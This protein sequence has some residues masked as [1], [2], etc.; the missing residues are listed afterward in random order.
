L[1]FAIKKYHEMWGEQI[2]YTFWKRN[3]E[4]PYYFN[5]KDV[6]GIF[7]IIR[8]I[9]MKDLAAVEEAVGLDAK[10]SSRRKSPSEA[11]IASPRRQLQVILCSYRIF[12]WLI[13]IDLVYAYG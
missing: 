12:L 1:F 9:K 2:E 8:N 13:A 7:S 11:H 10:K 3:D 4:I 5:E 6:L